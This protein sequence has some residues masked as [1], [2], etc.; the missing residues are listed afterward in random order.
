LVLRIERAEVIDKVI[1]QEGPTLAG[2][3]P[4]DHAFLDPSAQFFLADLQEVGCR[5]Q[6]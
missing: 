1:F 6:V 4:P 5:F 2:L 3:G